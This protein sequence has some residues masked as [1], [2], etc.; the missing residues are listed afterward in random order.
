MPEDGRGSGPGSDL[1]SEDRPFIDLT[2]LKSN[3]FSGAGWKRLHLTGDT[4]PTGT[5][6]IEERADTIGVAC[7]SESFA[8]HDGNGKVTIQLSGH[9][10]QRHTPLKE[11]RDD[12]TVASTIGNYKPQLRF[13]YLRVEDLTIDHYVLTV[14]HYEGLFGAG[15]TLNMQT[16]KS[17]HQALSNYLGALLTGPTGL[18]CS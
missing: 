18:E 3:D 5:F 14:L 13:Q 9:F 1:G 10:G 4:S 11:S 12:G 15:G 2:G 6:T 17:N 7:G 16:S 8:V